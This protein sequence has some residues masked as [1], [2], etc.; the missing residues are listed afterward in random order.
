MSAQDLPGFEAWGAMRDGQL[1]AS[2]LAF[3]CDDCYLLLYE[4]SATAH[5]KSRV[6][7]AI[8]FYVT[9]EALKRRGVSRVFLGL[10]S[11]DAPSSVD[12]FKIRM[13][14]TPK[15]VGQRVVFHSLFSP[16]ASG[17]TYKLVN[18]LRQHYRNSNF[19]AKT[20]G[21]LRFYRQGNR[22]SCEPQW[23]ERLNGGQG[24]LSKTEA[25]KK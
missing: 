16:F 18:A 25:P 15:R 13:G 17:M 14:Y 2:V 3:M 23:P 12:R 11:L 7:N 4:Q 20:E 6:N 1:I 24:D 10:Q 22:F 8:F 19:L 5:L 21:M 9:H